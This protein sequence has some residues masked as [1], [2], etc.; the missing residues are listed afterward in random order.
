MNVDQQPVFKYIGTFIEFP[1]FPAWDSFV[2]NKVFSSAPVGTARG[3]T[4]CSI[5][6]L[7]RESGSLLAPKIYLF[8]S[9]PINKNKQKDLSA[10]NIAEERLIDQPFVVEIATTIYQMLI[11]CCFD[12]NYTTGKT[13]PLE[14]DQ[15]SMTAYLSHL[16]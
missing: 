2:E 11:C 15:M 9:S 1:F 8:S 13:G 6:R 5:R 16:Q 7:S 14:R 10:F 3:L 4:G 12:V